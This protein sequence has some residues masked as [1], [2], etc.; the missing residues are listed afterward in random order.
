MKKIAAILAAFVLTACSGSVTID[1]DRSVDMY[2]LEGTWQ[3]V[4]FTFDLII[5][6]DSPSY[7]RFAYL[8]RTALGQFQGTTQYIQDSRQLLLFERGMLF[9]VLDVEW[10]YDSVTNRDMVVL[11]DNNT[12]L[13]NR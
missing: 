10:R 7:G 8:G 6:A 5:Y 11:V 1:L 2:D 13:I 9:A 4:D 12:L 3:E